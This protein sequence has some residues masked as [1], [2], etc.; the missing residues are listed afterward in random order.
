MSSCAASPSDPTD[1]SPVPLSAPLNQTRDAETSHSETSLVVQDLHRHLSR[2]TP[3]SLLDKSATAVPVAAIKTLLGVVQRSRAETMMGLQDD[4]KQ[5]AQLMM[6]NFATHRDSGAGRSHIALQSGCAMFLKYVTRTFLELSDFEACRQAVLER[7]E[8]FQ[9]ISLAARDRIAKAA[10]DFIPPNATVLTHGYSRVVAAI[11]SQASQSRHFSVIVLEGRPDA[12][13]P[14]IAQ[15]YAREAHI[16]VKIVLDAAMAYIMEQVD[17]VLVGA[18]GVMENG[19]VVN[20]L[21]TYTLATCAQA[22]GKPFYVAAESYKFARIYPLHQADL[23]PH[24]M[25]PLEFVDTTQT[26]DAHNGNDNKSNDTENTDNTAPVFQ[27][28]ALDE[29][30]QVVN[31]P[32]DFTPA[33]FITLLFTDL[34]VL[35]PS[36]VSDE[37]IRLYQ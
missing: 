5:A 16:P 30:I 34:G 13:G 21:G 27:A 31:P 36:A 11:L 12:S 35:T 25:A 26:T 37:L 15:F 18:E 2:Q 14:K 20:K 24:P 6:D 9:M 22:A 8:R 19:G 32:V 23:P 7:G 17:I 3:S 29:S 28:I 4:L 10:V 1:K 33:K